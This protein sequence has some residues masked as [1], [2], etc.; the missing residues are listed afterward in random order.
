MSK[1][2]ILQMFVANAKGGRTQYMLNMWQN[3]DKSRFQ[4]DFA[5]LSPSLDFAEELQNEGCK[6]FFVSC[7]A[8]DNY[9]QFVKEIDEIL[10]NGYDVVHIHSSFWRSFTIEERAKLA[11]VRKIILHSHNFGIGGVSNEQDAKKLEKKHYELREKIHSDMADYFLACSE[12][13][14]KWMYGN[15][16]DKNKIRVLRNGIDICKFKYNESVRKSVR[17]QLGLTNKYV[18]GNIGRFV[19]QKNHEF[20]IDVFYQVCKQVKDVVLLLIGIGELRDEIERKVKRLG[21]EDKVI[22]LGKRNDVEKLMQGMDLFTL[23]SRFD[24]FPLSL[25]EAQAAGLPCIAGNVPPNASLSE[26]TRVVELKQEV[27]IKYIL[28]E[29]SSRKRNFISEDILELHDI[30]IQVKEL[31]RI[32]KGEI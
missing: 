10:E 19:Y 25:L 13:A 27:W 12:E 3:I 8:E 17:E 1:I 16:I 2:K 21:I 32:Y 22:F 5:T 7:Y 26:R 9:E 20:L 28:E 11:G 30:R 14:A 29:Y 15:K 6:I 24:G 18:I 4:F 23:P 31:E